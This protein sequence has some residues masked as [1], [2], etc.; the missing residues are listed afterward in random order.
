MKIHLITNLFSP[1]ELAGAALFSDLAVFLSSEGHDVRVTTAFSYYPAWKIKPEDANQRYRTDFFHGI[2]VKR[3]RF[4]I[5]SKPTGFKRLLADLSFLTSLLIYGRHP[6]WVPEVV[7]TACPM[8]SQCLAQRFLYFGKK[9]PRLIIVQDF[10]VDAA[11]ELRILRISWLRF[12]FRFLERWSL[13]SAQV[14]T[15]ISEPMLG[16]LKKIVGADRRTVLIPNWIHSTLQKEIDRQIHNSPVRSERTLFYSGNLGIKQGLPSFLELFVK[17]QSGWK[18][19]IHGAGANE[20]AIKAY[21]SATD[22]ISFGGVL[23]EK[24]YVKYLLD[25]SACL[26]TQAPGVSANFLPSKLL[27]ALAS[28]TPV[29][30]VCDIESPLGEEVLAGGFGEVVSPEDSFSLKMVLNK[31]STNP[32]TL[33]TLC[34]KSI[35][36]GQ[37]YHRGKILRMF[38]DQLQ[39]LKGASVS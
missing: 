16:K 26:V 37:K 4:Y 25:C 11:L 28:G 6:G 3:L 39:N 18:L 10:V 38:L 30:A 27:P 23:S 19:I 13:R 17:I 5:P 21:G 8:L 20:R 22:E 33:E 34:K 14:L 35:L 9:I 36:W 29:L 31:W 15:T 12:L 32:V 24:G 2:P 1:D 7:V